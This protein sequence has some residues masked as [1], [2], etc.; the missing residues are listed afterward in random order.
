MS[1]ST[2]AAVR[3]NEMKVNMALLTRMICAARGR[4]AEPSGADIGPGPGTNVPKEGLF[5]GAGRVCPFKGPGR[6]ARTLPTRL[7][8]GLGLESA[9][10][11]RTGPAPRGRTPARWV[12]RSR[13][14]AARD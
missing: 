13:A 9:P 12:P 14:L 6:C 5:V 3:Q 8:G 1:Q 4:A 7:A 10:G 11:R 2:T